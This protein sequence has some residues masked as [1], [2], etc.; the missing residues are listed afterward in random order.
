MRVRFSTEL[1]RM[2]LVEV[3]RKILASKGGEGLTTKALAK[4]VGFTEGA[5]YRH[6]RGKDEILLTLVDEIERTLFDRVAQ[7]RVAGETPI[8]QLEHIF[9][10]HLSYAERRRGVTF[11]VIAE[12]LRNSNRQLRQRMRNVLVRYLHAIGA[13]VRRGVHEGQIDPQVDPNAAAITLFSILQTSVTFWRFATEDKPP[14]AHAEA[15]WLAYRDGVRT[16]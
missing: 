4:D 7:A 12:V 14:A 15:L 9:K 10:E 3:A 5:I 16:R 6:F 8:E 13:I 1:R 2:E 11:L